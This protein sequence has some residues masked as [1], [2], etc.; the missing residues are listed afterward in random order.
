VVFYNVKGSELQEVHR[1]ATTIPL[2]RINLTC[3]GYGKDIGVHHSLTLPDTMMNSFL[4]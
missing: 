3:L 2:V 1:G 4:N